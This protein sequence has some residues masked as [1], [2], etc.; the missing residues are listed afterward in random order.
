MP[1][2]G[3]APRRRALRT[4]AAAAAC[5]A[6]LAHTSVRAQETDVPAAAAAP[7]VSVGGEVTLTFGSDDPH[8]FNFTDY[9]QNVLRLAL[10]TLSG[11]LSL[12]PWIDAVAQVR[13][14]N[15]DRARV[16]ALYARLRP[17]RSLVIAAGRVP[18][19]FGAFA[20]SSYR[21]DSPLVSRPL[22]YQYLSTLRA[23]AVPASADALLAVRG[24]GWLVRYPPAVPRDPYE[25]PERYASPEA[26]AAGVP[27][28]SSHRWD[29][30]VIATAWT[31]TIEASGGLTLG[32]LS[33]PRLEDNNGGRQVVARVQWR[34]QAAWSFGAS[35]AHGGFLSRE[36]ALEAGAGPSGWDQTA[37]AA[38]ASYSRD[39]LRVRGE[40]MRSSWALPAVAEPR[41]PRALRAVATTLEVS[42]RVHPRADVALRADWLQFSRVTGTLYGGRAT[43]WDADVS[44]VEVGI[45]YRLARH[46]SARVAYQHNWRHGS[47]SV[48][49]G[50]PA[51]QLSAWF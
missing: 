51:V 50:Y 1:R 40:V 4:F 44:R 35:A 32:S 25:A 24:R 22:G 19:V 36:A 23:D 7:R 17:F 41:L 12:A 15:A 48:D 6:L 33:D 10:V 47:P 20:R 16:G 39:H 31:D 29:T 9:D 43:P 5:F 14:E 18:P 30:G 3:A 37:V 27:I 21:S 2:R 49:A 34:P 46:W 13:T 11:A 28:V 45:A 8:Y 38:D 42:Q 26:P